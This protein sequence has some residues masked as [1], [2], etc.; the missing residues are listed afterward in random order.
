MRMKRRLDKELS[1][2]NL[3]IMGNLLRDELGEQIANHADFMR[4]RTEWRN[5][6]K[7]PKEREAYRPL[8]LLILERF[9]ESDR[10]KSYFRYT[11]PYEILEL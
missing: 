10:F 5:H 1:K 7:L 2:E 4:C 11:K 6:D 3:A 9:G 8:S